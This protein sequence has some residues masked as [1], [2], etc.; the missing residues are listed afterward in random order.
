[1]V[2][3]IGS[4]ASTADS[5]AGK[6]ES[7]LAQQS[8]RHVSNQDGISNSLLELHSDMVTK[9]SLAVVTGLPCC[10]SIDGEPCSTNAMRIDGNSSSYRI[11]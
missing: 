2:R 4:P 7:V 11:D 5:L 9:S 6:A 8:N 1:V 10:S 3:Q